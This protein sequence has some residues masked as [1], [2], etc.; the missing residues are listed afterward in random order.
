M[1]IVRQ[2]LV[3]VRLLDAGH[4]DHSFPDIRCRPRAGNQ[5]PGAVLRD[6]K[7]NQL[8]CP[9]AGSCPATQIVKKDP[10]IFGA[11]GFSIQASFIVRLEAFYFGIHCSLK[12]K[13]DRLS[14][15]RHPFACNSGSS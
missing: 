1:P 15:L 9:H 7:P 4:P 8:R 3:S 13:S 5:I 2:G 12:I 11:A 6:F 14:R 10:L